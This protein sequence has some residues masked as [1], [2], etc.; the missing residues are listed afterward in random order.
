MS[1][2]SSVVSEVTRLTVRNYRVLRDV[3]LSGLTPL[4]VLLGPN[5][6]GKS[7]LLDALAFLSDA[8]EVGVEGAV[9]R[10]GGFEDIRT[11]GADGPI[12]FIVE[13][14]LGANARRYRY[15]LLLAEDGGAVTKR[16]LLEWL[17]DD[18]A[19][20]RT[21]VDFHVGGE[22][23]VYDEDGETLT[24]EVLVGD[25]LAV[26]TFGRLLRFADVAWFRAFM[27]NWQTV[28]VDVARVRAGTRAGVDLSKGAPPFSPDGADVA[29]VLDRLRGTDELDEIIRILRRYVPKLESVRAERTDTGQL[30]VRLKDRT[31][32]DSASSD[33][34]SEGT[35]R[36]L[37]QLLALRQDRASLLM[38][39]EPENNLHPKLHYPLAEDF[40]LASEAKQLLV[41][42]HSPRFVDA[43][44]PDE[45]WALHRDTDGYA[46][47]SR[48]ADLPVVVAMLDAG[49]ALGDLWT[50][51]F[52][53]A[54]DPLADSP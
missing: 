13:C 1:T 28:N 45:L 26:D 12:E 32:D 36:L 34:V 11:F 43:V 41:A 31:F 33:A 16:E 40:R 52:F 53:R 14:V 9:A 5:G 22:G 2:P 24:R 8:V 20:P 10:R 42:T 18:G 50:E 35:L 27:L 30:V 49:G 29:K 23:N 51:G 37:A 21:L 19:E 48:A 39:E 7:T 38:V 46:R 4:T 54:G 25:S 47:A 17:P 15:E 6:S 3:T 44:R